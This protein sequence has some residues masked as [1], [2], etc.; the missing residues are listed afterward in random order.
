MSKSFGNSPDPLDLIAKYGADGLRFGLMRIAPT[1]QDI[2]FDE[3]QIE[4]G[5]NFATSSGT[6]PAS[7]RCT[8]ARPKARSL[9]H[10]SPA[11]TNGSC[12]GSTTP[13][14]R[15]QSRCRITISAK[16]PRRFTGFSGANI[17][18][19]IWRRVKPRSFCGRRRDH[20]AEGKRPRRHRLHPRAPAAVVSSVH[21][22]HHR[23]TL[24]RA[25]IQR[26]SA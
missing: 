5:R 13:S 14:A 3:K 19:G 20:A 24:A 8:A 26:R 18:I 1:G 6:P 17:A 21:A 22:L 4:E 15:S 11:T 10:S 16:R 23:G 25:R 9:P 12:S 7:A 2:R